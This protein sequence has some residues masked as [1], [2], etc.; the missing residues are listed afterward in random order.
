MAQTFPPIITTM[1]T[2]RISNG[3]VID[4]SQRLDQVTDLW[5]RD[6]RVLAIGARPDLTSDRAETGPCSARATLIVLMAFLQVL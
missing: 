1:N 5:I 4:P 6:D 2:L 3:R